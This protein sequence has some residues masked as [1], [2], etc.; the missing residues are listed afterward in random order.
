MHHID[1]M[2]QNGTPESNSSGQPVEAIEQATAS[3]MHNYLELLRDKG[4]TCP[5]KRFQFPHIDS[6]LIVLKM[7]N[8]GEHAQTISVFAFDIYQNKLIPQDAFQGS[9]PQADD[10]LRQLE[11]VL[12][13]FQVQSPSVMQK[14]KEDF[15]YRR[16]RQERLAAHWNLIRAFHFECPFHQCGAYGMRLLSTRF[17]F[18]WPDYWSSISSKHLYIYLPTGI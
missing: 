10:M 6:L 5:T 4:F 16:A 13:A 17:K 8:I 14:V 11:S 12:V 18:Q 9:Q 1:E 2:V 15:L 3:Y 7:I